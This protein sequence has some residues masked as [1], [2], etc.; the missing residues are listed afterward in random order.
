MLSSASTDKGISSTP[1]A[2]QQP[3]EASLCEHH[4]ALSS[5]AAG[6]VFVYTATSTVTDVTGSEKHGHGQGTAKSHPDSPAALLLA[7]LC[8]T[9]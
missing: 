2:V 8:G 5:A 9:V 3:R 4:P 7:L 6:A 1:G